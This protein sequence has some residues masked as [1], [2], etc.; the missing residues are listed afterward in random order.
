MLTVLILGA[1]VLG[2]LWLT[3]DS[4]G[5]DYRARDLHRAQADRD[6]RPQGA[7]GVLV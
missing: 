6:S 7:L 1:F 3:H 4:D 5:L 2:L